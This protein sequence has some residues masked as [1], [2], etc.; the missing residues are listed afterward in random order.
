MVFS[1]KKYIYLRPQKEMKLSTFLIALFVAAAF[2]VPYIISGH[3]YFIFFGDFNVQQIPFYKMCHAAVKSGNIGWSFTTDLGANFIGSYSFYLLGSPFFWLTLPFPNSFVP[4]LMGPLLILK[5]AC[6]AFTAYLYIRRFTRTPRAARLGAL[7]YAFSGFSVYNIFFNHFHEAIIIFPLLLLAFEYLITED[8]RGV[9]ALS[10]AAAAVINYFFFFG[11][12][13]FCIIYYFVR[14]GTGAVKFK[15]SRFLWIAF[16]SVLG[17]MMAAILLLPSVLAVSGNSRLSDVLLG[18]NAIMYGKEQIY[19]NIIECFFFP[20]DLPAR[21][22]FFPGA[23]VR[24]SSL[25]GWMPFFGMTG[26]LTWFCTKKKTWIKRLLVICIFMSLV[27]ILNSAFYGFNSAYYARWFYMPILIMALATAMVCEDKDADMWQGFKWSASITVIM[28]LV[29]GLFPKRTEEGKIAFGLYMDSDKGNYFTRYWSSV[30]IAVGSVLILG[31]LYYLTKKNRRRFITVATVFVCIVSIGYSNIFVY[32]GRTH[33]YDVDTVMIDSL[34]EGDLKLGGDKSTY[35]IDTFDCVDNTGMFLGYSSMNA[36]HSIV[37][38]SVMD[39]YEYIGIT[40]DVGSRPDCT[41]PAIRSLFSV[42]Y[43]LDLK[44]DNSF[45]DDNGNNLI[46]GFEY[47][48][49]SGEYYIYENKNYVGY[50]FSYDYAMSEKYCSMYDGRSASRMM[51]KAVLLDSKQMKKYSEYITD[52]STVPYPT[53]E[54]VQEPAPALVPE[55]LIPDTEQSSVVEETSEEESKEESSE[56]ESSETE[57]E[58]AETS[59][60]GE[61][62][63]EESS[64]TESEVKPQEKKEPQLPAIS[65]GLTDEDMKNDCDRLRATAAKTFKTDKNGFTATVERKKKSLVFFSIPYD[66]GWSA[67]VNG[68]KVDIE[69]V[70]VGFMAVPVEAGKST[71]RFNYNTPGF[72]AGMIITGISFIIFLAYYVLAS[73]FIKHSAKDDE[74]IYPEG[75]ELMDKWEAVEQK[76]IEKHKKEI[77]EFKSI[78]DGL[79]D[80]NEQRQDF[81]DGPGGGF[82]INTD[83]FDDK[84]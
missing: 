8:R 21:P 16:E 49:S 52:I 22:V 35:R 11:M 54:T 64:A 23:E 20:P 81:D 72:T 71:I 43:L 38:A 14:I 55:E 33:S 36:F 37:P 61:S 40:R 53:E 65:L 41:Y 4:Y 6:A 59:S 75:N 10:V 26:V 29:I 77:P 48:R 18:W 44:G 19:L 47:V 9:F 80:L 7:L 15:L 45:V 68:K 30:V 13:V 63:A 3:G 84:T 76:Q 28:A 66:K 34:I 60:E 58:K 1:E 46:P 82:I 62:S 74:N 32:L 67:T 25:G 73:R 79:A 27:P 5:F 51:L 56:E 39:F 42:K 12:V 2:F 17:V 50:G 83:V 78:L 31:L 69:K 24:W 57:S 70:N